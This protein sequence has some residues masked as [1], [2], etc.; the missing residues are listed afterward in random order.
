MCQECGKPSE[1]PVCPHCLGVLL[2]ADDETEG[3]DTELEV[4]LEAEMRAEALPAPG[5]R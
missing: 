1:G 3:W 2:A 5:S 4:S